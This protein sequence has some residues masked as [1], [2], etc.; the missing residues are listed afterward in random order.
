MNTVLGLIILYTY[1]DLSK[2]INYTISK[3]IIDNLTQFL[4]M[5]MTD[6][7]KN[8]FVSTT[9]IKK[10]YQSLGFNS[11]SKYKKYLKTSLNTRILQIHS[12]YKTMNQEEWYKQ[13]L[14]FYTEEELHT[15]DNNINDLIT[16]IQNHK[17]LSII[18]SI[19]SNMIIQSFVEDMIIMG[20]PVHIHNI[21]YNYTTDELDNLT[22]FITLS[23]R[24][25]TTY[26]QKYQEV[27]SNIKDL[28]LITTDTHYPSLLPHKTLKGESSDLI[29]LCL[30]MI[31][32]IKYAKVSPL[33]I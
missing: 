1:Q 9:S 31:I 8:C 20:K 6:L 27:T 13:L 3:Y 26:P 11:Y 10:Y 2:D 7:S 12:R 18:G 32:K 19:S 22:L 23:G 30:F 15:L 29:L 4:D 16:K 33:N 14:F 17:S 21:N 28:V 5:S 25:I 24:L